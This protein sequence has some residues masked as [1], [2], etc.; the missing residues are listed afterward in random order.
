MAMLQK[1]KAKKIDKPTES[2]K[3]N[4]PHFAH[5]SVGLVIRPMIT[6]KS[7]DLAIRE[8]KYVFLVKNNANKNEIK[9]AIENLYRVE[10]TGVNMINVKSKPRRLGRNLGK[11]QQFKKAIVAVKKGQTIDVIPT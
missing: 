11:T 9:K 8:N 6:E 5:S 7:R 4:Q 10:V 1:K 3:V 2:V